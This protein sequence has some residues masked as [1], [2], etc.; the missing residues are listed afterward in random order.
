MG[1]VCVGGMYSR[2]FDSSLTP[3]SQTF[4]STSS[5]H[6]PTSRHSLMPPDGIISSPAPQIHPT[7][8]ANTGEPSS[9]PPTTPSHPPPSACTPPQAASTP[10]PAS[11]SRSP[12]SILN[13]STQHG[14]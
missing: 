14:K 9:S 13:P 10:P 7:T 4:L 11:A 2:M 5:P 12:T 3:P 6:L 1:C 8:T